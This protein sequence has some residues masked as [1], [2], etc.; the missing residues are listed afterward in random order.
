VH[1]A[2]F[3]LQKVTAVKG[4]SDA[5]V[6][7]ILAAASALAPVAGWTNALALTHK[8]QKSI[9]RISTGSKEVDSILGGG[10]ETQCITEMYGEYRCGKTQLC[11]TV[12]FSLR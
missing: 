4:L 7:K 1:D 6:E 3:A 11:M 9:V 8:R 12:T 5:K 10:Y 2:S